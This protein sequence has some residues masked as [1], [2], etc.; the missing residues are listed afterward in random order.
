MK[1][2]P[3]VAGAEK[4][5]EQDSAK[6]DYVVPQ[7]I[8][9]T[10]CHVRSKSIKLGTSQNICDV[11]EAIRVGAVVSASAYFVKFDFVTARL[12]QRGWSFCGVPAQTLS[13]LRRAQWR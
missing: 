3:D 12:P 8:S 9:K 10:A 5:L 6:A 7:V 1:V 13:I 4:A 11:A 2:N